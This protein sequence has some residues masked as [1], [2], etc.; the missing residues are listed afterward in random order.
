MSELV[1]RLR[2]RVSIEAACG[3]LTKHRSNYVRLMADSADRIAELEAALE[4][5]ASEFAKVFVDDEGWTGPMNK[6]RIV[7]W[8]GPSDFRVAC[9]ALNP[10]ARSE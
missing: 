10:S 4:P 6:E 1:E 2:A 5:F 9:A 7:D 8:F 3:N